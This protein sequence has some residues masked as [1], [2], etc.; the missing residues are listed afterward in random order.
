LRSHN[1][2]HRRRRRG[3]GL[4]HGVHDVI[5]NTVGGEIVKLVVFVV[6]H[7]AAPRL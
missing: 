1:R 7:D 2:T 3:R 6:E 5:V 4:R